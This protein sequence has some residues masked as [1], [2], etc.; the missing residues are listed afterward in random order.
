MED[1]GFYRQFD[2]SGKTMLIMGASSGIGRQTA[3]TLS[4]C[5][6][7]CVLVARR[8][9]MLKETIQM[10]S[11]DGHK[12]YVADLS[13]VDS[14]EGL[15]KRI[16]SE[17]GKFQGLVFC[18]G[19]S[20]SRPYNVLKPAYLQEVMRTN[21]FSFY[22]TVRQFVKKTNCENGAK[23]VGISSYASIRPA[24]GQGAY[25]ASKAAMDAAVYVLS[26]ELIPRITINTIHPTFVDTPMT[27]GA[28]EDMGESIFDKQ[29][30]GVIPTEDVSS[31]IVYL[32]SPA[33]DKITGQRFVINAG[34]LI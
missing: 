32:L 23:V 20:P 31:M 4:R 22:E 25:A 3:I 6:A 26:Q 14:I 17:C 15:M 34:A 7:K 28:V 8:G 10:M 11:G 30:L 27:H 13:E 21:F 9:D 19:I 33:A 18:T 1:T 29:S 2:F 12:H 5:G 24:K 16:V